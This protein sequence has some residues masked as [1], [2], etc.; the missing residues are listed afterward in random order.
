MRC[1]I[2]GPRLSGKTHFGR[3]L[4][5][6]LTPA[7]VFI[8]DYMGDYSLASTLRNNS[9]WVVVVQTLDAIAEEDMHLFNLIFT[10][11]PMSRYQFVTSVPPRGG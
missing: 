7:T 6:G 11:T 10:H 4:M 9:S 5:T 8:D 2:C 1:L 3:R